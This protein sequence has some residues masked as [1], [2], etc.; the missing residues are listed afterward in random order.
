MSSEYATQV[1]VS[2][3]VQEIHA[4]CTNC[5]WNRVEDGEAAYQ[6]FLNEAKSH[7]HLTGHTATITRASATTTNVTR[8]ELSEP[9]TEHN[10]RY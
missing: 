2:T 3:P 7:V 5:H 6:H 8:R 4:F 1:I 10:L 9:D